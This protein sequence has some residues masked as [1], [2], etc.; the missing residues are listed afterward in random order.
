MTATTIIIS[1]LTNLPVA[2]PNASKP[3]LCRS[4][5]KMNDGEKLA[6]DVDSGIVAC[7]GL[8]HNGSFVP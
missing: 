8:L 7:A 6:Q 3:I 2:G 1:F 5:G 4:E